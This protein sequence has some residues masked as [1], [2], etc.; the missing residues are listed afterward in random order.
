MDDL[1]L[2]LGKYFSKYKSIGGGD[3]AVGVSGGADSMALCFALSQYFADSYPNVIIH[4]IT[5]DH[6][7]RA[8]SAV[9]AIHVAEQLS[10]LSNVS[11]HILKWRHKEKLTSR[12]QEAARS[13]RYNLM[14][15]FMAGRGITHLFLGHH[16][17]DQA[18]TFLFR[19][20]KGSGVDGL[21]CMSDMQ[22]MGADFILCRPMLSVSK[23]SL[24]EFCEGRGIK[25]IDD[26][27]NDCDDYARVRIRKS[28]EILSEE[29]LTPKR[30][31]VS[32][33]RH[34]R[35][36]E[37]L[38]IFADKVFDECVL[39]SNPDRIVFNLRMLV[40]NPEEIVFPI[41]IQ[42][43]SSLASGNGYGARTNKIENLC[44]DL[45]SS[46][47]FRKRT[48]GGVIFECDKKNNQLAL[49]PECN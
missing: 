28:M 27:S 1:I 17:D 18:E 39:S 45:T 31:A 8:E 37:A 5:V 25:F 15:E 32:A 13:A 43:M 49:F 35:A 16:M 29:G 30:L 26:P 46:D 10:E 36:R 3:I 14:H 40:G 22:E 48:L 34:A 19:L 33:M 23:D 24:I 42:A 7:L 47:H 38:D 11:H 2:N 44:S 21:S 41:V 12:V 4:A 6:G 20:A 9:E